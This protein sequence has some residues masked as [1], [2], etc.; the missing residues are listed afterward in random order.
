MHRRM[1]ASSRSRPAATS[2]HVLAIASALL[3]MFS[4]SQASETDMPDSSSSTSRRCA[5]AAW[6]PSVRYIVL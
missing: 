1:T 3:R 5:L 4:S 2:R 6:R